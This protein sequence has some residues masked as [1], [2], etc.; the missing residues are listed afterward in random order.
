MTPVQTGV[1]E[2][3]PISWQAEVKRVTPGLVVIALFALR[4]RGIWL[5]GLTVV[6]LLIWLVSTSQGLV[7]DESGF[8]FVPLVPHIPS[9]L[10]HS[11]IE[12]ASVD[13]F[14][15]QTPWTG[16]RAPRRSF[17]RYYQSGERSWPPITPVYA[18]RRFAP[19]LSAE[20]LCDLL[21]D[22]LARIRPA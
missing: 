13:R 19:A 7:L 4:W 10:P 16:G 3:F 18:R 8:R 1:Y 15:V 5:V 17:V 2:R 22:Q 12:W 9:L 11:R 14:V 6:L 21:N 20:Q